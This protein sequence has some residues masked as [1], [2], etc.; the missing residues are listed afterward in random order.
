MKGATGASR[1]GP[2]LTPPKAIYNNPRP[3]VPA[4]EVHGN[5]VVLTGNKCCPCY[6]FRMNILHAADKCIAIHANYLIFL[7][8]LYMELSQLKLIRGAIIDITMVL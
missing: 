8:S 7:T 6:T 3:S 4:E 1:A 2:P 5:F